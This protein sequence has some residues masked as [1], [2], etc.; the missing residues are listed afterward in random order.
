MSGT[1]GQARGRD[2]QRL[3][4]SAA[5]IL[6]D[7]VFGPGFVKDET[8]R[9]VPNLGGSLYVDADGTV[10]IRTDGVTL[11]EASNSPVTLQAGP[12]VAQ[13]AQ[14]AQTVTTAT[15]RAT[16]SIIAGSG[17]TGGGLLNEDQ[18]LAVNRAA[19]LT[20]DPLPGEGVEI[21]EGAPA[22]YPIIRPKSNAGT[23]NVDLR[24][25]GI[26]TGLVYV[27]GDVPIGFREF[28]AKGDLLVGT[29]SGAL[30]ALTAGTDTFVLTADSTEPSGLKWAAGGSG[31][32]L[33]QPQIMAR[34]SFGGF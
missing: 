7:Q 12:A 32:G 34:Q 8:G 16:H 20:L 21:L 25:F 14:V 11:I 4:R 31:S 2:P 29:G 28:S 17:L 6:G 19:T 15:R 9:W 30:V 26:G 3:R 24:L 18:T 10:R 33:S 1:Y 5:E 22:F 13:T 23:V 27:N